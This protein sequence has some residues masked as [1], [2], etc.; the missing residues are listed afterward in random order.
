MRYEVEPPL[1]VSS[2]KLQ[3]PLGKE[4]PEL[5]TR[6]EPPTV[7][8]RQPID[9]EPPDAASTE[10]EVGSDDEGVRSEDHS[11]GASGSR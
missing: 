9:P 3:D 5:P 11:W 6:G 8:G 1:G 7:V 10:P 2:V 4:P